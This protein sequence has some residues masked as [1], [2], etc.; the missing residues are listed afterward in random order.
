MELLPS[1]Y[2]G[3]PLGVAFKSTTVWDMVKERFKR[4]LAMWNR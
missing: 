4:R 1:K 2:I 3:L